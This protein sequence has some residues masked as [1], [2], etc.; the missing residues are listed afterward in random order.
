[1]FTSHLFNIFMLDL[2]FVCLKVKIKEKK[3][4]DREFRAN[5]KCLIH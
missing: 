3:S 5:F 4:S 1:M 2:I